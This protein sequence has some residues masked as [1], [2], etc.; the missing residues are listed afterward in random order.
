MECTAPSDE[1][2][3]TQA[4]QGDR[5]SRTTRRWPS[6][7]TVVVP[8]RNA[9]TTLGEQLEAL[10]DQKYD[11]DWQLVVVDNG[12]S[13]STAMLARGYADRFER[14]TLVNTGVRRGYSH[15]RNVGSQVAQ[16][17]FLA[18]CDSD[19]V[20]APGWLQAM[21]S[22]ACCYDVIGGWLNVLPL[23]DETTRA[24][25]PSWR[26]DRLPSWF[27][28][29]A[30]GANFGIWASVLRD[31]GGWS[32]A[33]DHGA[34]DVDLSWRAQL[35]GFSIGF[36]PDAIVYYRYRTGMWQLARQAYATGV[37]SEHLLRDYRFLQG[38]LNVSG[39]G[40]H[41]S[42]LV[43]TGTTGP[44]FARAA[45]LAARLPHLVCSRRHRGRWVA[46]AAQY[47]GR[48]RGAL[49]YRLLTRM[50]VGEHG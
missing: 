3:L 24:W 38:R 6:L 15:A 17:D 35:A 49:H 10:A 9:A 20:V 45:W 37:N 36:A 18:F 23:N 1:G 8:A 34:E 7:I 41:P 44:A 32:P 13:D 25:R 50:T 31:L 11:G 4:V 22:A 40:E 43:R 30:V 46:D 26:S 21:G 48:V 19:D 16:G 5:P 39:S 28:P 14:F 42:A 12:S 47:L 2:T 33:Y 27:L 29:Y